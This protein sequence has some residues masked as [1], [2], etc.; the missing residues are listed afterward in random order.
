M[1]VLTGPC[2]SLEA[3]G[4]LN[5]VITYA[6]L[7]RTCYAKGYFKPANPRAPGQLGIRCMTKFLTQSWGTLPGSMH[8]KYIPLG[9]LWNT[10]AYHAFLT[11]NARRWRTFQLP[12]GNL[13]YITADPVATHELIVT[14]NHPHYSFVANIYSEQKRPYCYQINAAGASDF[15]PARSNTILI[16]GNWSGNSTKWTFSGNWTDVSGWP[17]YFKGRYGASGG[18]A[19]AFI[20]GT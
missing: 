1:V 11:Y 15:T 20:A 7:G 4:T 13:G 9:K 19:S 14:D 12:E 8:N 17:L 3:R 16:V 2:M 6:V 5:N 10:S 18:Q